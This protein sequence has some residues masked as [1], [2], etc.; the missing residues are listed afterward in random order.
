[1]TRRRVLLTSLSGQLGGMEL[2]LADEARHL[3]ARGIDAPIATFTGTQAG[4]LLCMLF[5]T[6]TAFDEAKLASLYPTPKAFTKAHGKALKR[7]VKKGWI[8]KPDA[9][10]IKQWAADSGIGG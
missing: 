5:G 2:R 7:A 9:K 10:L 1:M 3:T 8:L 6:T 4:S